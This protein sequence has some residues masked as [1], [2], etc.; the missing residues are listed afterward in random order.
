M[1]SSSLRGLTVSLSEMGLDCFSDLQGWLFHLTG[2]AVPFSD[3]GLATRSHG[4]LSVS[5]SESVLGRL[6]LGRLALGRLA[7]GRLTLG[8]LVLERSSL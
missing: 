6:A 8:R 3:L 4:G 2:F 1:A 5:V 7:L